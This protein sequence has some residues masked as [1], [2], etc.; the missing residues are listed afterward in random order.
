MS[1]IGVFT[2][3]RLFDEMVN[4]ELMKTA[5]QTPE[6]VRSPRMAD[7][8]SMHRVLGVKMTTRRVNIAL[9]ERL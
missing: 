7:R 1:S 2:Q 6:L 8:H 3:R 4:H 9:L 5:R